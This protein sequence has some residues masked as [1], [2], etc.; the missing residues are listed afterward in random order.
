MG[1]F[2][3]VEFTPVLSTDI[4][5]SGDILFIS[6]EITN[7]IP[8]G[9]SAILK[10]LVVYDADDEKAD[11]DF[12]FTDEAITTAAVN[13]AEAN[14]DTENSTILTAVSFVENDYTDLAAG[15]LGIQKDPDPGMGIVLRP[16][17]KEQA[18]L[19]AFGI[20]RDTPT[21]AAATNLLFKIGLEIT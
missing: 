20:A 10:S 6:T 17:D 9:K 21:Y 12:V 3:L 13:A 11:F 4:Y 14:D 19:W 18:S 8:K 16:S 1:K 15:Q 7:C 2:H 5:A